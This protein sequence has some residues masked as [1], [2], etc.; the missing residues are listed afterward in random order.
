MTQCQCYHLSALLSP[1]LLV[2]QTD[3]TRRDKIEENDLSVNAPDVHVISDTTSRK[4]FTV[5]F[6]IKDVS[7]FRLTKVTR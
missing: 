3:V 6:T 1:L 2:H 7:L 5:A 4:V